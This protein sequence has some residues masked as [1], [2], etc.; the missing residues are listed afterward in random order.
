M[1]FQLDDCQ[2]AMPIGRY[3]LGI[4]PA[5]ATMR[6]EDVIGVCTLCTRE[7]AR[8]ELMAAANACRKAGSVARSRAL[9]KIKVNS[10][11]EE[12]SS[13]SSRLK[14]RCDSVCVLSRRW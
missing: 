10:G 9:R 14:A 13:L 4:D 3:Q 7:S 8:I 6:L 5:G 11:P 2:R 12:G 1:I